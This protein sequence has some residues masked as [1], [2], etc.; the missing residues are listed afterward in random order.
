MRLPKLSISHY[1]F[2][3]LVFILLSV[4]GVYSYIN[5]P[6]TEN[7]EMSVPGASVI[8]IYPGAN[9]VDLEQLIAT[10]IE[11]AV[12][13]LDDIK[14]IETNINDGIVAV[15]VEFY[16]SSNADD[17]YEE[18]VRQV[19][20]IR[21]DLPDDI[22]SLNVRQWSISDV[23]MMQ[24]ALISDKVEYRILQD[25]A[26]KLKQELDR[27]TDIKKVTIEAFPELE[28]RISLN[29][30]KM[31]A[32]NINIDHVS[33]ALL[34]NNANIPGGAIKLGDKNMSIKTSGSFQNINEIKNIVVNSW[35]GKLIYLKNIAEVDFKYEDNNYIARFNKQK[36]IFISF[37]Q[38]EGKNVFKTSEESKTIIE[39][40]KKSL[41]SD[42]NLEYVFD[43]SKEVKSL[44]NNFQMNLL[45]GIILVGIIIFLALGFKSSII[46]IIAIPLSIIMGL[47]FIDGAGFGMEQMSIAGLVVALGL[48]VDNSIVMVENINRFTIMGHK[49]KEAAVKA[50]SEI[51]WPIV[52]ATL[53]TI[54]AFIPIILMP[55]K[56][57]KFIRSLP[58]T[59]VATLS[60]S[61]L[62]ALTLTPLLT[63]RFFKGR[64]AS[65]EEP[66]KLKGIKKY[67]KGFIE[68]PY[69]KIL[70]YVLNHKAFTISIAVFMLLFSLFM[71]QYVGVSF[72]PKAEKP[73]FMIDVN[74]PEGTNIDR[75]L[76]EVYKVEAVLEEMDEIEYYASNIG[77]GN[78]RI[79][80]N[81]FSKNFASNYGNIYVKLE[82]YDVEKFDKLINDLRTRFSTFPGAKI[83]VRDFEQGPPVESPVMIYIMGDKTQE[84]QNISRDV[85]SWLHMQN[86]AINIENNLDKMKTDLFININKDK[87]SLLGVPIF[88]IDKTVRTA[89][90]GIN[91]SKYRDKKGKEY[92]IV[93]R[94][95]VE[96]KTKIEDFDKIFVKSMT[97]K[98][99]PL[100]QIASVEFSKAPAVILRF[101]LQ[102]SAIITADLVKGTKID[103]VINP[104]K[105]QFD[106]YNFPEGY[107]YYIGGEIE[108]RE[109]SF[110]GMKIA[111]I[112][113]LISI[114]AVLVLQFKSFKQ[115]L[116]VYSAIPL[117]VIGSIWALFIT[118]KS[119]SFTAFIGI[120]SLVGIVINNSIILV[121]YTNKL[122]E[123]GKSII[124]SIKIA[125]ET[126][127]TPIILTTL[128]TIGGL[129][130]IT[131]R[132]G[133]L[134][135]PMGW[136]IIGGLIVS[137]SLTLLLV[138]VLYKIFSGKEKE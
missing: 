46:V 137:T 47:A 98:L 22:Y 114:F 126:R 56:T 3:I 119:F 2:T 127:F 104:V 65:L 54:L 136:S 132:G 33:N 21:N 64:K 35:M 34:S 36:A 37:N 103:D 73:Q 80:Y 138:P 95:P 106:N 112:I 40:F 7:P 116:I 121:D 86:G 130:P 83:N 58:L 76:T 81:V 99:I 42:I 38:K 1:Q 53:T 134:W 49:P 67:L 61:L 25:K 118:G 5:M 102:K 4:A 62:I 66:E 96:E 100:K 72:F 101:N 111:I 107:S 90:N 113:A 63:S 10:R 79:F 57:G 84:L 78:P 51:G 69:R 30:E 85:E 109:E 91:V 32:M 123:R 44:I 74:L 52:S 129:L 45:Q 77:H 24:L 26:E 31:A 105:T 82:E 18:V 120:T 97:G 68:G 43:Q 135:A 60:F 92:N 28:I 117:A 41:E 133:Q 59:I 15:L 115:P 93:L 12:N 20:S 27:V 131:L 50:A 39:N 70:N 124:E 29:M 110:G 17:K 6:R 16:F 94:L 14:R 55:E 89:M 125:G 128:T 13:E 11:D 71:F 122:R 75:T 87:A 48:L 108:S 19:N 9:P 88:E 23:N 8:V